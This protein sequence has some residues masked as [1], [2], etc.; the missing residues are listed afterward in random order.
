MKFEYNVTFIIFIGTM[1][2]HPRFR[3]LSV[4]CGKYLYYFLY[5]FS[6][7]VIGIPF[8]LLYPCST[9]SM[10]IYC[11]LSYLVSKTLGIEWE[12]RNSHNLIKEDKSVIYVANHQNSLDL[13]GIVR[14]WRLNS[15]R[16]SVIVKNSLFWLWPIGPAMWLAG[17]KFIKRESP[18]QEKHKNFNKLVAELFE[19]KDKLAVFVE[20]TRNPNPEKLLPFK[21]G[22]FVAAIRHEVPIQPVVFSPY[23]FLD[24]KNKKFGSGKIIIEVLEPISTKNMTMKDLDELVSKT[25][26]AMSRKN[27]ELR[28]E[29][30][31]W[32]AQKKER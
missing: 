19:E 24:W 23:Y 30:K 17:A 4:F 11:W 21:K 9:K 25:Y 28:N 14:F 7:A 31:H 16:C 29:I 18:S 5:T 10:W 20:G 27:T 32:L 13:I 15:L 22:A 1:I 12:M 26:D 6:G 8:S 2:F 3:N